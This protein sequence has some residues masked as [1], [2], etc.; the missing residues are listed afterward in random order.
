MTWSRQQQLL[1]NNEKEPDVR[2]QAIFRFAYIT[3]SKKRTVQDGADKFPHN[4]EK[5]DAAGEFPYNFER[6][7]L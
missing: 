7:A 3:T 5:Q 6:L 1:I 4:F 2:Q